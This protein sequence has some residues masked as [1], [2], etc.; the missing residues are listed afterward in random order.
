MPI[1]R[2]LVALAVFGQIS[3]ASA[4]D[5]EPLVVELKIGSTL[6]SLS[7]WRQIAKN[8]AEAREET[9]PAISTAL[10]EEWGELEKKCKRL[11][12]DESHT[13]A[14]TGR[15]VAL[16]EF[17]KLFETEDG[18]YVWDDDMEDGQLSAP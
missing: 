17:G 12:P 18:R 14:L 6:C 7:I 4:L 5:R 9:D 8:F 13:V 2:L 1:T 3:M 11:E 16:S 15:S 10:N